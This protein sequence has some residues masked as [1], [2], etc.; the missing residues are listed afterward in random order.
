MPELPPPGWYSDG[1]GSTR[2][3]DGAQWTSQV[4]PGSPANSVAL[5]SLIMGILTPTVAYITMHQKSTP[6][7]ITAALGIALG[8]WG[9]RRA[10][11]TRSNGGMAIAGIVL[12]GVWIVLVLRIVI[13]SAFSA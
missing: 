2:W 10:K 11:A 5:W 9:W 8:I 7:L 6:A 1:A 4:L 3:W 12:G 13:E